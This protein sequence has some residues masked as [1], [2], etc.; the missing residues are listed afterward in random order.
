MALCTA[1]TASGS[2]RQKSGRWI[3]L[4][5]LGGVLLAL[6]YKS[7][8]PHQILFDND[9][10]LG[11]LMAE[12]NHMPGRFAGTWR[13][14][15]WLG[16]ESPAAS[17][18]ITMVLTTLLSP[19]AYLK[20]YAPFTLLFLGFSAW[21]F[22]RQLNFSPMVCV[23]G[24]VAAALN[25]HFFSIACW[26]WGNWNLSAG[27]TFLAMA[28]LYTKS[29]PKFWEKAVLAGLAVGMGVMEGYDV[30]AILSVYLGSFIILRTF[31][32]DVPFGRRVLNAVVAQTLVVLFAAIIAFHAMKTVIETQLEEWPPWRRTP[33][34]SRR[35][36]T[37]PPNGAC[38]KWKRCGLLSP[39]FLVIGS[40]ATSPKPT[41]PV[42]I[43]A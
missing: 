7:L 17:P 35:A 42:P 28:A 43:G 1:S 31:N 41:A 24:G 32:D 40:A 2:T 8:A 5:L 36:G 26:G 19:V 33:K 15:V 29:I 18:N 23:L 34:P 30:G 6:F 21:L 9:T 20:I 22:F 13:D 16:W 10:P 38:L 3:L 27:C 37:P 39:A 12:C 4:G 25:G 14:L 11:V